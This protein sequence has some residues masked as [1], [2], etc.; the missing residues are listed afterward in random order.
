MRRMREGADDGKPT[1]MRII[2]IH[3]Y[4]GTQV[5]IN[6]Q[7]PFAEALGEYWGKEWTGKSEQ[8]VV[9]EFERAGVETVLVA[10]DI[11][12]IFDTP[13]CSNDY[14]AKLRD[15]YPD[16]ILQAWG[17]VDPWKGDAA[18][19]EAERA[20]RELGLLGFHFHPI[21]GRYAVD[22]RRLYPLWETITALEVPVMIDVGTTG[23]GAG[24]PG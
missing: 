4:P 14:V 3:A 11:E 15:T 18:T 22:D 17:A 24:M 6:S 1:G 16:R 12:S 5:W 9:D 7:G 2:D 20:I 23:M 8:E 13:P 10:L 21:V 19:V